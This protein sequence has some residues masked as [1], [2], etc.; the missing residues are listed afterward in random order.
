MIQQLIY[1]LIFFQLLLDRSI[2]RIIIPLNLSLSKTYTTPIFPIDIPLDQYT[3]LNYAQSH[4]HSCL[5][6]ANKAKHA[7]NRII[8]LTDRTNSSSNWLPGS[9]Y[10]FNEY[11]HV[12][13][14]HFNVGLLQ[15]LATTRIDRIILQRAACS[16]LLCVGL[17]TFRSFYAAYF[18]AV[19]AATNH[20]H[21]PIYLRWAWSQRNVD[22]VYVSTQTKDYEAV[23]PTPATAPSSIHLEPVMCFEHVLQRGPNYYG[24]SYG[25]LSVEVV[26]RFK[27]E[28]EQSLPLRLLRE[29]QSAPPPEHQMKILLSYRGATA[30]RRIDNIE[31]LVI[32]VKQAW[33]PPRYN[34]TTLLNSDSSLTAEQQIDAV[35]TSDVVIT[36]HGAFQGNLIYMRN[37]SLLIELSGSY[38]NPEF[39]IFEKLAQQFGVFYARIETKALLDHQMKNYTISAEEVDEVVTVLRDYQQRWMDKSTK[40]AAAI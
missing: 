30:S 16:G 29:K 9:T 33:P 1:I 14:V 12:G 22:A 8:A 25:S 10:W 35:M 27:R 23:V 24:N 40:R 39:K 38:H 17:G 11:L 4:R 15:L 31:S 36:N 13:H 20:T 7:N 18:A 32:A 6:E 3:S 5:T 37:S 28:I 21:V 34:V 2:A 26:Q 19:L